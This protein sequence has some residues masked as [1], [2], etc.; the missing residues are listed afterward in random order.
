[1][2]GLYA[3]RLD[4]VYL[5]GVA[6]PHPEMAEL[7][8]IPAVS[9]TQRYWWAEVWAGAR[10]RF[11]ATGT[12]LTISVGLLLSLA[13]FYL[14]LRLLIVVGVPE[15]IVKILERIDFWFIF[16]IFGASGILFVSE[17]I[18][19]AYAQVAKSF[20]SAIGKN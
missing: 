3:L 4:G 18:I 5:L 10:P 7:E 9:S 17:S 6:S 2:S 1:M 20:K 11:I 13:I 14:F 16:A 15:D 12:E 8:Q 19:G